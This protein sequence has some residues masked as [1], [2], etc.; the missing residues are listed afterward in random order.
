[1][2][3]GNSAM[4]AA[5]AASS[6]SIVSRKTSSR[7][8][9]LGKTVHGVLRQDPE[10]ELVTG[11]VGFGE[12]DDEELPVRLP[13]EG[14]TDQLSLAEGAMDEQVGQVILEPVVGPTEVVLVV[15]TLIDAEPLLDV[16][17]ELG[18][19]RRHREL[20]RM[21]SPPGDSESGELAQRVHVR[22]IDDDRHEIRTIPERRAPMGPDEL[23]LVALRVERDR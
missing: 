20:R 9:R 7:T 6:A 5:N 13:F 18:R 2:P 1:M 22:D 12:P 8:A 23:G 3:A 17:D 14:V 15:G 16:D 11:D 21:C 19:L 10:A 4:I